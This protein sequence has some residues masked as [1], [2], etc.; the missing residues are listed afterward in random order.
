M[1]MF[2]ATGGFELYCGSRGDQVDPIDVAR[3]SKRQE[4]DDARIS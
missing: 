2:T 1:N 4:D 3:A